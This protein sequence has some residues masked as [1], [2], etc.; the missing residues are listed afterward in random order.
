MAETDRATA[1][2][3]RLLP[4][5]VCQC[6]IFLLFY[7]VVEVVMISESEVCSFSHI[8]WFVYSSSGGGKS[9]CLDLLP[10]IACL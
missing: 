6:T 10:G 2:E 1:D 3:D 5:T 9:E 7:C 8:K 4:V